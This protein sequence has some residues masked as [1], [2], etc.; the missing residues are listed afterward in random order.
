MKPATTRADRI[1]YALVGLWCL[2]IAGIAVV[3]GRHGPAGLPKPYPV[4]VW[5]RSALY[6]PN[7]SGKQALAMAHSPDARTR[8]LADVFIA[9]QQVY[10]Y[11]HAIPADRTTGLATLASR[12]AAGDDRVVRVAACTSLGDIRLFGAGSDRTLVDLAA[13]QRAYAAAIAA[14]SARSAAQAAVLLQLHPKVAVLPV[15]SAAAAGAL[16][17]AAAAPTAGSLRD[18][19][20]H[21]SALRGY[22]RG[23]FAYAVLLIRHSARLKSTDPA[24]AAKLHGEGERWIMTAATLPYPSA[25]AERFLGDAWLEGFWNLTPSDREAAVWYTRAMHDGSARA[26]FQLARLYA[27]GKIVPDGPPT[28]PVRAIAAA[29]L[30]AQMTK[31]GTGL[32]HR[33]SALAVAVA[34]D[35][36]SG[37]GDEAAKYGA[38]LFRTY[39]RLSFALN[40]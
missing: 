9:A 29:E 8:A 3:S 22:H 40:D 35:Q 36:S 4:A 14:G 18:A 2:M 7:V 30:A 31:K 27:L 25:T 32:H 37:V 38:T 28:A 16:S 5:H 17:S 23:C 34:T 15:L 39:P 24:L 11:R 26:A 19:L 20:Y 33:A 21:V 12:C 6:A 13:A 1:F 10:G